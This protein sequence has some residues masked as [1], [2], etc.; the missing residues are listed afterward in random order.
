MESDFW[1]FEGQVQNTT[2]A[3]LKDI[4]AV[5]TFTSKGE[6]VKTATALVDYTP[7]E[8]FQTTTFKVMASGP[9]DI[10]GCSVEFH[11]LYGRKLSYKL[12][13]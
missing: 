3:R 4:T 11:I 8:P 1:F 6:F 2:L 5:V 10:D 12:A 9:P 13:S 7:L